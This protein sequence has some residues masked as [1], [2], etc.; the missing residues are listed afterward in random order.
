MDNFGP[1]AILQSKI[2]HQEYVIDGLYQELEEFK[3]P[4]DFTSEN[5][6]IS[7]DI[8]Y[9][10]L[11]AEVELGELLMEMEERKLEEGY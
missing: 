8:M 10:I 5:M 2:D 4:N 1:V 6:E 7:Q 9:E 11:A 3:S